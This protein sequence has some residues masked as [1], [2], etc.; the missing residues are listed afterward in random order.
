M[1]TRQDITGEVIIINGN[2]RYNK[3]FG[4]QFVADNVIKGVMVNS[5][6][7][8][9]SLHELQDSSSPPEMPKEYYDSMLIEYCN[10]QEKLYDFFT[11][12]D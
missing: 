3:K 1:P 10:E 4:V 9:N 7:S 12:E 5:H 8:N 11:P 6:N 2:V